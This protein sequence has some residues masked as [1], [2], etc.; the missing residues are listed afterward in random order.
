[1]FS[2]QT[3]EEKDVPPM[4]ITVLGAGAMGS[5]YGGKLSGAGFDV[6]LVDVWKEHVSAINTDGL[7]VEGVDGDLWYKNLKA[8]TSPAEAEKT[9]LLI[10]FVKSTMTEKAIKEAKGL[11]KENTMVLT[12][13]N[14]LGNIDALCRQVGDKNVIAGISTH[15]ANVVGPGH[16]RHPGAG[17]TVLGELNGEVTE[18]LKKLQDAFLK[19]GLAPVEISDNVV[20]LVWDKLITNVG[21]NAI[22]AITGVLNGQVL[23]IPEARELSRKA[24]L[25]AVSVAERKGIRL[26]DDPVGHVEGIMRM[27][28]GNR[29]S[30]LQDVTRHKRTEIDFI[31]L[32]IV[33]EAESLGMQ[34]PVNEV[35]GKLVKV[36]EATYK[37]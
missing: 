4:K 2:V 33:R 15:G 31:N 19:A 13:Q 23:D 30:M 7:H 26:C 24:V 27:T 32:A 12:L 18:R 3:R 35:L 8:V 22:T 28:G 37:G 5:V 9:D 14:G 6:T 21:L 20:G 10:V 34:V 17:T 36:I 25:E 11:L 1:M 16:I 29:S